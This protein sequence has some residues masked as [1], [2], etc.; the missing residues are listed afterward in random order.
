MCIGLLSQGNYNVISLNLAITADSG[1]DNDFDPAE[2]IVNNKLGLLG[3][4]GFVFSD[5][6]DRDG[7]SADANVRAT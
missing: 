5:I 7:N 2:S 6:N 1:I 4:E 3:L